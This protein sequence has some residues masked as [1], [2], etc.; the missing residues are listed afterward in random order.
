MGASTSESLQREELPSF[1][2][3]EISPP[4]VFDISDL[5]VLSFWI[6]GR[7]FLHGDYG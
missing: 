3:S 1:S 2:V 6:T 4:P 5:R 7:E